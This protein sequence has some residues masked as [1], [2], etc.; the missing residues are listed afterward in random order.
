MDDAPFVS[1]R[2][3][4]QAAPVLAWA[5]GPRAQRQ[6]A[7]PR[8]ALVVGNGAYASSPLANAARDAR[9]MADALR[10]FGFEVVERIDA[11]AVA[12]RAAV[13]EARSRLAG[14][15]GT[16][17]F[18]FAGHGLQ[19]DWQNYLVPVD[20]RLETAADVAARTL[21]LQQVIDAFGGAGTRV[22]IVVLDACR[23][24]PFGALASGRGLAPLDA[25]AGTF[26]AYATAPGH[27]ALDGSERDGNGL[28]TR[29]LLQELKNGSTPIEDLFKRVRLQVRQASRGRQ[30]PWESTSLEEAFFFDPRARAPAE[31]AEQRD[32]AFDAERTLWAH[33]AASTRPE[34]FVD[35]LLRHPS[36]RIAELAQHRLDRLARAEPVVPPTR[37]APRQLPPGTDRYRVGD[38]WAVERTDHLDGD[39]KTRVNYRV[40]AIEGQRVIIND[41][42]VVYDQMG[43]ILVNRFG[44]KDP[45]ILGTPDG[46]QLGK[47]W[48]SA[49]TNAAPGRPPIRAYYD[50]HVDAI[51]EVAVPAGRFTCFRIEAR[52]ESV[53]A[54][55]AGQRLH[56]V[57][58]VDPATMLLVKQRLRFATRRDGLDVEHDTDELLSMQL[59]PR[60]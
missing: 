40:T 35:Y 47:R 42:R 32:A 16:G 31:S 34:D 37:T 38:R 57:T 44:S 59:V 52:G 12:L 26:L 2:R 9:Q 53:G 46:L 20:A 45:V 22:N 30:V 15:A 23:D 33:I 4:L 48:R 27:V 13:A 7:A 28:Y 51:E 18:Y 58:W 5:P 25:P 14:R 8:V 11:D 55:G 60:G 54:G 39:R 17:L 6:G 41:G 19:L 21:P 56:M 43:G 24:N 49:F 10:A 3:V 50:H 29:V 1:R 36:G